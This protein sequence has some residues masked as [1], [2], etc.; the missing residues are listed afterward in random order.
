MPAPRAGEIVFTEYCSHPDYPETAAR[1]YAN[2]GTTQRR[3][4]A[5]DPPSAAWRLDRATARLLPVD[6]ARVTCGFDHME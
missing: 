1:I 4:D 2:A 6:A 3:H 5:T